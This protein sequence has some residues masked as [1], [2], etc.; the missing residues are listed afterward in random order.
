MTDT[1]PYQTPESN[2]QES[3][4][5]AHSI[6][7]DW[8]IEGVLKEAWDLVSGVKASFWGAMLI[9]IGIAIA[10]SL[11]FE[12]LGKDSVVIGFIGQI[13][14]GLLTYP[15]YAAISIMAIKRSVN[16]SINAFMVFDC[17][18]K[19]IPIFLLYVLMM[20]LI[21]LGLILLII[22][23]IYLMVAYS[24]AIPL[25]VEKKMGL[26][27]ALETSRKTIT[28]RWFSVFALYLI[29]FVVIMI[30]AIPLGIGL[31]WTLPFAIL[32]SGVIYRN[33]FGVE[34]ATL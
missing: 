13:V 17:Y 16:S 12:L 31:I 9:Y 32:L 34:Q 4:A 26:W 8:T 5:V 27:E 1:N 11:P 24:S 33:M 3:H 19:T 10:V 20:L 6:N 2:L 18:S 15:L 28:K 14:I 7:M 23:G 21:A 30:S 25:L 29:V 22:P